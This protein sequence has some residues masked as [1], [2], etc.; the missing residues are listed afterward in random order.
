MSHNLSNIRL[1]FLRRLT[2]DSLLYGLSSVVPRMLNY[3]LVVLHSRVFTTQEY[4]I[5]TE[6]YAYIAVLLILLTFGLE[7]GFFR[8]A[9]IG[10]SSQEYKIYSTLFYFLAFTST[11]FFL[12]ILGSINFSSSLL[13]YDDNPSFI[14]LTA[15][16]ISID[17][18]S[19]IL[20]AR[21]RFQEK[22]LLFSNIKITSVIINITLNFFFLLGFPSW[23]LYDPKFGVGYVLVSNLIASLAAW[24]IALVTTGGFPKCFSS[25]ILH[26]LLRYSLPLLLAGL[27]GASNEFFDRFFIKFLSPSINPMADVGIYGANLKIAVLLI[28]IIQVFR[29]ALEPLIFRGSEDRNNPAILSFITRIFTLFSLWVALAIY[30]FLPLLQFLV[31]QH[32]RVGLDVIPILLLANVLYGLYFNTSFWFKLS[33]QTWYALLIVG[34]GL[35]ITVLSNYI[36]TPRISYYGAAWARVACYAVMVILSFSLSKKHF[37]IPYNWSNVFKSIVAILVILIVDSV[38]SLQSTVALLI[39]RTLLLFLLLLIM[40]KFEHFDFRLLARSR[41]D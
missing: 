36:L 22:P 37:P 38:V 18:H 12:I 10:D 25:K 3:F 16:I 21:I 28:L 5:I 34:V 27:G 6:L 29:Y 15:G 2:R 4:G 20:F 19:S 9:G 24:I 33:G 39:F 11:T 14:L 30:F 41:M 8:Y 13:L 26:Q 31:G 32:F 23:G 17:A 7:T 1:S 40:C 35:L